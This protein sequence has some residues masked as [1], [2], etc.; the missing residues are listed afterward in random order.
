MKY[1][2]NIDGREIADLEG[3]LDEFSESVDTLLKNPT[4]EN[5]RNAQLR[6]M[7]SWHLIY[8]IILLVGNVNKNVTEK[9][10]RDSYDCLAGLSLVKEEDE[11]TLTKYGTGNYIPHLA[12][13]VERRIDFAEGARKYGAGYVRDKLRKL[14]GNVA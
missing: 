11:F 14:L 3:T 12:R 5:S 7:E 9:F 1:K 10:L 8:D 13:N 2:T 4:L 6:N